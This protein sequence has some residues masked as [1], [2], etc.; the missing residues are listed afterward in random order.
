LI[1]IEP[2]LQK[3]LAEPSVGDGVLE[4]VLRFALPEITGDVGVTE[5]RARLAQAVTHEID[6]A[7]DRAGRATGEEALLVSRFPNLGSAMVRAPRP[8]VEALLEQAG[9]TGATLNRAST[10]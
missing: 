4:V 5:R 8:F 2:R 1:K 9:V 10:D 6:D 7:L 3:A